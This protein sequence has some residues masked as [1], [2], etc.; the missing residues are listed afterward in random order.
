MSI[1]AFLLDTF[2]NDRM[3]VLCLDVVGNKGTVLRMFKTQFHKS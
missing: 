1:F 3:S 2:D